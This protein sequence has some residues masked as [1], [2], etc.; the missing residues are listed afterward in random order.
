M[1]ALLE[2]IAAA[3]NALTTTKIDARE[4]AAEVLPGIWM[5]LIRER[6]RRAGSATRVRR[7]ILTPNERYVGAAT[8]EVLLDFILDDGINAK[9]LAMATAIGAPDLT[10]IAVHL[11]SL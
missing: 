10:A 8:G 7:I 1:R 6:V 4:T 5:K 9:E 2:R 3:I 11:E